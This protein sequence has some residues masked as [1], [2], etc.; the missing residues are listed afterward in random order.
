MPNAQQNK[1]EET[2]SLHR[3]D[4][5]LSRI[6]DPRLRQ[7]I[8]EFV[9]PDMATRDVDQL[10][11]QY[12]C[13]AKDLARAKW[14][15][16]KQERNRF[17]ARKLPESFHHP[18]SGLSYQ[19]NMIDDDSAEVVASIVNSLSSKKGR[20]LGIF[21]RS[22]V[23][24]QVV[25][26]L[27]RIPSIVD[28]YA[29]DLQHLIPE[30]GLCMHR[31]QNPTGH[32][33]FQPTPDRLFNLIYAHLPTPGTF[34]RRDDQPNRSDFP[35]AAAAALAW[36]E[37]DQNQFQ[38]AIT[39]LFHACVQA[40]SP[41]GRLVVLYRRARWKKSAFRS[42]DRVTHVPLLA[43]VSAAAESAGFK[44]ERLHD[45]FFEVTQN[46][47]AHLRDEMAHAYLEVFRHGA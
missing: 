46:I 35:S 8:A 2:P 44:T 45:L 7:E 23:F 31:L 40:L 1:Q 9:T 38:K 20:V 25:R 6:R 34:R 27:G 37:L 39:W 32:A 42:H 5:I 11:H 41:K 36:D 15:P 19:T 12:L 26:S 14:K 17:H 22:A 30:S 13:R 3:H 29:A 10:V 43:T 24:P 47:P 18:I 4:K 16:S 33:T 28:P 21:A